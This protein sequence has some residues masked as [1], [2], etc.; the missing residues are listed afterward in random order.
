MGATELWFLCHSKVMFM[1]H[2]NVELQ[3][4]MVS[5]DCGSERVCNAVTIT[6]DRQ[7]KK[8]KTTDQVVGRN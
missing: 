2:S 5:R 1:S 3:F 4:E 7:K 8:K 6:S